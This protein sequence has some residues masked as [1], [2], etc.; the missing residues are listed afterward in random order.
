[1]AV[2][3]VAPGGTTER[4]DLGDDAAPIEKLVGR[5]LSKMKQNN[6]GQALIAT[7]MLECQDEEELNEDVPSMNTNAAV[8]LALLLTMVVSPDGAVVEPRDGNVWVANDYTDD[9]VEAVIGA[10]SLLYYLTAALC[11][12]GIFFSVFQMGQ[13]SQIKK[14]LT[15]TYIGRIQW[16]MLLPILTAEVAIHTWFCATILNLSLMQRPWVLYAAIA[17]YAVLFI[18]WT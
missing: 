4:N 18:A 15:K 9:A 16:S 8:C 12:S 5:R 2:V 17:I 7:A 10:A 11:M 1:M 14:A 3:K 13:L 6:I